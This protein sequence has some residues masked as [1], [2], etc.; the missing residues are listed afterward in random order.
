MILL[1]RVPAHLGACGARVSDIGCPDA[2]HCNLEPVDQRRAIHK[3]EF[4]GTVARF[5]G[6]GDQRGHL[7]PVVRY[8]ASG[9]RVLGV[10]HRRQAE[11]GR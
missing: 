1:E 6:A 8:G 2:M 4:S 11:D 5:A 3:L 10:D 7:S 9:G